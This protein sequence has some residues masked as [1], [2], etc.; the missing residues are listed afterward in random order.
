MF[1]RVT[2]FTHDVIS[3]S[4]GEELR[5]GGNIFFILRKEFAAWKENIEQSGR[6]CEPTN[7]PL[8]RFLNSLL[9]LLNYKTVT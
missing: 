7:Q 5:F 9:G 1:Q 2:A 8:H 3:L 6:A 4:T